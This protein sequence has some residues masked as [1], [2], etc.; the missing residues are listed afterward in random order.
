MQSAFRHS[1]RVRV[2]VRVTVRLRV[3]LRIRVRLE[4]GRGLSY[5]HTNAVGV[6]VMHEGGRVDSAVATLETD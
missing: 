2:T 3:R 4:G 5:D 1:V 6:V